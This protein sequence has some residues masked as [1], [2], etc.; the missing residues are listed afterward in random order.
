MAKTVEYG[1]G[2][3]TYPRGWFM[4]AAAPEVTS[5][6]SAVRFFGQDLVLYRGQSGRAY[7]VD[8]YCPHMGTHLAKNTT[9]YVIQDGRHV[10]GDSIRCPYHAWQFGPDGR[11][12]EIPYSKAPIPAAARLRTWVLEERYGC[13][14]TWHDPEGGAPDFDLPLIPEWDHPSYVHW[15]IDQLGTLPCHP[16]E[17]VDN[18]ADVA[19]LGPTH[20]GPA[21]YFSNVIDGVVLRQFQGAQHRSLAPGF[22]LET[23]TFYTGPGVLLSYF[24]GAHAVM[25][26]A[27]TPVDD[28]VV[29][30]WHG[31]LVHSG[32]DVATD[33]DVAGARQQQ[34][35]SLAALA[36]DFEIWANKR[37]CLAA[38]AVPGDGAFSKLRQWYKQFYNPK[39]EA[40]R[41]Q[42]QANGTFGARGLPLT[43]A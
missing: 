42:A 31:L 32:K 26:I 1:L 25:Y 8:A 36:Q 24:N 5:V 20:G 6:P 7:M 4:V 9:S 27:H 39:A 10:E 41:F 3:F 23:N 16:Q 15:S 40:A 34:A 18:M 12:T 35:G 22:M 14:F 17:I 37:A 19:H 28:G 33:D 21:E 30:A 43:R 13:L 11:C 29:R 38:L 2:P